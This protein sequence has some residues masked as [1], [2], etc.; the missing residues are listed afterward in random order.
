[1]AHLPAPYS[2][3]ADLFGQ[4]RLIAALIE[5]P[6]FVDD[7]LCHL[8]DR[9]FVP[10]LDRLTR[11]ISKVWIELSDASG[12]PLFIS[13]RLFKEI[14][15]RPVQ[16]L[17]ND[18]AWGDRVFVANY[19]GDHLVQTAAGRGSRRA[20]SRRGRRHRQER[21]DP[22]GAESN[23]DALTE[24]IDFKLSICPEFIIKLDADEV[25]VSFYVERAIQHR[26]PLYLGLGATR[27]D[28][29]SIVDR[30]IAQ[31]DLEDTVAE[32]ARA[33]KTVSEALAHRGQPRS[34][35]A[36]P[37]DIYIEDINVESDLEF[38]K[39]I[40]ETVSKH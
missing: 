27:I 20:G 6:D 5:A 10:W 28:R 4:E 32:Y 3:A 11:H 35:L 1:V 23:P 37:G 26:K 18:Y 33:I 22:G 24:L 39:T 12:S 40:V 30:K 7:F 14:A 34:A 13:P 9:I 36:W 31:R 8:T 2:L 21:P 38:V 19:R 15:A 25:P 16:R 17:I 29:N